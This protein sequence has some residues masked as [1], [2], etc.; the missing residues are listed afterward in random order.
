[1]VEKKSIWNALF[2]GYEILND[3]VNYRRLHLIDVR[4]CN[5]ILI[6]KKFFIDETE[7]LKIGKLHKNE[8]ICFL[9]ADEKLENV[10]K[11]SPSK[12]EIYFEK[13][14]ENKLVLKNL[15]K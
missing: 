6:E 7:K 13:E 1:M 14:R 2:T 11:F 5:G 4:N 15:K 12:E 10:I 9:T 8:I 3:N